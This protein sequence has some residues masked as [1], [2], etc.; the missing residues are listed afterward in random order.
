MA[1]TI[2]DEKMRF[3]IVVNGDPA[4]KELYE[5]EK[6][7]RNLKTANKD[8]RAAKKLLEAQN[9][10]GTP[11]WKKLNATIRKN[12]KEIKE[13]KVRMDE[14]QREIGVTGLSMS[15]LSQRAKQL[16]AQLSHM[17]PG[18]AEHNRLQ[19]EL[20]Q[21]NAQLTKLKMQSRAAGSSLERLADKFNRFTALGAVVIAFFTGV[22]LSIQKMID[23]NGKLSD[24][25]AD[26]MKTTQ[27]TKE[28]V[29]GLTKSFGLLKSRTS[30]IDLL[31]IAEEG[32]RIGIA[33]NEIAEFVEVMNMATVA[34][35]DS[36]P[37]GVEEVAS[38]LGKL[39][40]L[41]QETRDM[42]VEEA[43]MAIGSAINDLGAA[44]VATEPNIAEF[45]T[46]VGALP[47]SLRPS[48]A[49]ALA[50]GAA[51]EESGIL[52]ERAGRGYNI[53]VTGA[54]EN[55][56]KFATVMGMTTKEVR[57]LINTDPLEFM[58]R[59]AKG[60]KGMNA[61]DTADTL[62]YLGIS[63]DVSTKMLGALSDNS[64]RFRKSIALSNTSMALATSLTNEYNI[65]NNNLAATIEKVKK[66]FAGWFSSESFVNFLTKSVTWVA[67]FIGATDDADGSVTRFREAL[68]F[69]LKVL[70]VAVTALF[71]YKAAMQL[72]FLW[73]NNNTKATALYTLVQKASAL[74]S[75]VAA[76]ATLLYKA[77]VALL[78]G[79]LTRAA[80]AMKVFNIV[81]KAN[82]I[83]LL[84]GVIGAVVT[85]MAIFSSETKKAATV[86]SM[87][88]DA[89]NDAQE[90]N[91]G[92]VAKLKA[93]QEVVEDET[94]SEEAR[95]KAMMAINQIV[96]DYNKNLDLSTE[97]LKDGKTAID[98]Y[99]E[100][101]QKQAE[102][103]FLADQIALKSRELMEAKNSSAVKHLNWFEHKWA[104]IKTK[105]ATV[106]QGNEG[107]K[108]FS[109]AAL[110]AKKTVVDKAEAEL[111]A[112]KEAYKNYIKMNPDT[113]VTEDEFVSTFKVPT[114]DGDPNADALQKQ[115]DYEDALRK[116]R[117]QSE[118]NRISFIQDS[119]VREMELAEAQNRW[120]I[121]D[122]E[123]QKH[124]EA[125]IEAAG[126]EEIRK[127]MLAANAE[128]NKQIHQQQIS[129]HY[130][131]GKLIM[132][133]IADDLKTLN[134]GYEREK[135]RRET[136]QADILASFKGTEKEKQALKDDFAAAD[137]EKEALH[138]EKLKALLADAINSGYFEGFDLDLL[139]DE[140]TAQL[141]AQ[142]EK[143]K[144]ALA[145]LNAEKAK[146]KNGGG[147]EG[148]KP[149]DL[150]MAGK[151]DILGFTADEW[152]VL[153]ENLDTTEG[154][155]KLAQAGI[156]AILN[157]WSMYNQFVS[158]KENREL[159]EYK[160]RVA[161]KI[162]AQDNLYDNGLISKRQHDNAVKA[163]EAEQER[164]EKEMQYKQAKRAWEMSLVQ[165][166]GNTALG[167][168]QALATAP[169]PYSF[170]LAALVS[171]M[172]GVQ[173]ATISAN[174]P[175]K[176]YEQGLYPVV[177]EQ[178]GK[179]FNARWGG[180]SRTG[181]VDAPTLFLAGEKGR[182]APEMIIDGGTYKGF[183]PDFRASLHREIARVKGFENGLYPN[184][185]T[186]T[187]P[188]AN[189]DWVQVL[190]NNTA[191][192]QRNMEVMEK[193][194]ENGV[195]AFMARDLENA[196]K[197]KE[198]ITRYEKL[199][200]KNKI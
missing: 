184:N 80:A 153:F 146:L 27:M 116:L 115:K 3:T 112:A 67:K 200:N 149:V 162:R 95:K 176:G 50:L 51:F 121:E 166:I 53:L 60:M 81:V 85:A 52:A 36:F 188:A 17:I 14:L 9:K 75:K 21:T 138:L 31:K 187:A 175:V 164:R 192:M 56:E 157:A 5:V 118:M 62:K 47:A 181:M 16:N 126:S 55:T 189:E 76:G 2:R 4:Q 109:D 87:L 35:S 33:K 128:L 28:E 63:A 49:E 127:Q 58:I 41:F 125:E 11:E 94:A 145:E 165:A 82:P 137:L 191:V 196:K 25:M 104:L 174:K 195:T 37:N 71:S 136:N 70:L 167:V 96:P 180:E 169:P 120:K 135:T 26:V 43:Y 143:V 68:V 114:G 131:K 151:L 90:K 7:V 92:H 79:N 32:G 141:Q 178:D 177:R 103:Q 91:A 122:L 6:R 13:N 69:L 83:G 19:A 102:A 129:F 54:A 61:T 152:Q 101:L 173:I 111:E 179:N 65:K 8:L 15:Q 197:I 199:R 119:F 86:Q 40:G 148:K 139:T 170:I 156:Q 186:T 134:E 66:R 163:M 150:G 142:L 100:S 144:L 84:I 46:R 93:L 64:E 89:V 39:K 44:G 194:Q 108:V 130:E 182:E 72:S 73:T 185:Q 88:A 198:D 74:A 110:D 98:L 168:T 10:S 18:S 140:E 107:F 57:D 24:A 42:G 183:A 22:V 117:R 133:G 38:K 105:F 48:I 1:K 155:L 20:R 99:T 172:G 160:A 132:D 78:T 45:A 158:A 23:Y 59:F 30:R 34:L 161:Q 190:A 154:K 97:A 147:E 159:R 124:T 123:A 12:N 77:A 193:L 171:A 106:F 29:D 113:A